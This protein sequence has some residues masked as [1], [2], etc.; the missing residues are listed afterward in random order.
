MKMKIAI[1]VTSLLIAGCS[2]TASIKT[3]NNIANITIN[4]KAPVTLSPDT[5]IKETYS[6]TSF[7]QYKFKISETNG[8]KPMYGVI[9]LKFNGGYLAADILL[10]A[11]AMF[12]NLREFFPFYEFN[13]ESGIIK[14]KK[15]ESDEWI[16]YQPTKDEINSAQTYFNRIEMEDTE[17]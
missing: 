3:E 9:P 11:P 15:N 4:D 16:S 7:G 6:T 17:K 13:I 2:S 1:L 14:Y 5:P 10:F 12:F 8:N